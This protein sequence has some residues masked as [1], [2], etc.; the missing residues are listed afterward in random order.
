MNKTEY[1]KILREISNNFKS[2]CI[3]NDDLKRSIFLIDSAGY[4]KKFFLNAAIV[5]SIISIICVCNDKNYLSMALFLFIIKRCS[6]MFNHIYI[7]FLYWKY[8]KVVESDNWR[9]LYFMRK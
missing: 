1:M 5:E 2:E 6:K 4:S 7:V 8:S 9:N 3:N